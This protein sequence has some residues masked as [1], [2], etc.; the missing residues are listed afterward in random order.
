[1]REMIGRLIDCG[2]SRSVAMAA[3]RRFHGNLHE[4]ELYVEE[5]EEESRE[6]VEDV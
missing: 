6:Q 2:M 3:A 1:M 5:I 4:L